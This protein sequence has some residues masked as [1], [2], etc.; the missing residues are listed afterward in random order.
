MIVVFA[1]FSAGLRVEEVVAGYEFKDLLIVRINILLWR[2]NREKSTIAA[3]LHT[4]VLA[5]HFAPRI[6]SG[7]RYCLV[8]MSLVKWCPVQHALPKSAILTEIFS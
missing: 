2:K 6:T 1:V 4:S 3:I 5:P 7:E 8:W